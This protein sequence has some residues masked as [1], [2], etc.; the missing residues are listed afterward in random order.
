MDP[1]HR[2]A[3]MV[4]ALFTAYEDVVT[5]T[6]MA[7]SDHSHVEKHRGH[8]GLHN[9]GFCPVKMMKFTGIELRT[10]DVPS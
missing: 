8:L 7:G 5:L 9:H 1:K 2:V 10:Q 3:L 6:Y 4:K